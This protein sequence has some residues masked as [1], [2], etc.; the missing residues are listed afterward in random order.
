MPSQNNIAL[1]DNSLELFEGR[2][3]GDHGAEPL[4]L[5]IAF[6][7][8]VAVFLQFGYQGGVMGD[9]GFQIIVQDEDIEDS[10]SALVSGAAAVLAALCLVDTR[11]INLVPFEIVY[12]ACGELGRGLAVF[13]EE[14]EKPL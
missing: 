9:A 10:G 7:P 14:A 5:E 1:S 11:I 4:F 3:A 12:L 8:A 6:A 2:P 13:A